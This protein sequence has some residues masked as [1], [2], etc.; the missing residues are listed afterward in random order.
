MLKNIISFFRRKILRNNK[1]RWDFQYAR[2]QWEGLKNEDEL[3]RIFIAKELLMKFVLCGKILEIGCGEGIF[4]EK[5]SAEDYNFY[6][7]IDI[8]E[9][10]IQKTPKTEKGT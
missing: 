8:S 6:E 9:V 10:A 4:F 7:G 3:K 5:I 1:D 2:G